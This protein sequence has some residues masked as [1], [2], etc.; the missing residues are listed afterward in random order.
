MRPWHAHSWQ[1]IV[2]E[3][4][5]PATT[6][7]GVYMLST[8]A[9]AGREPICNRPNPKLLLVMI[10]TTSRVLQSM[11]CCISHSGLPVQIR[12]SEAKRSCPLVMLV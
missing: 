7:L 2:G 10:E 3:S 1:G 11:H 12:K 5:L 4:V 8:G 9:R 6:S